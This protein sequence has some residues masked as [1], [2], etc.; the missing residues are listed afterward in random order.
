MKLK[1]KIIAGTAT[2]AF[3]A[4]AAGSLQAQEQITNVFTITA[5]I[6]EQ[7]GTNY[8]GAVTTVAA[9]TKSAFNTKQILAFLAK[10]EHAAGTYTPTNFP[11]GAKLVVIVSSS[12]A[13]SFCQVLDKN[14][15]FLVD[16]TN[17]LK[18]RTNA[19]I[20]LYSGKTKNYGGSAGVLGDPTTTTLQVPTI[21]YDDSGITNSVGIQCSLVGLMKDTVTY[22]IVNR[23]TLVVTTSGRI[24]SF[25]GTGTNRGTP[26]LITGSL[27]AAGRRTFRN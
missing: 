26:F 6:Q 1:T 18:F 19:P 5:T 22:T 24:A 27:T 3:V 15:N 17:I 11:P 7:A 23:S 8:N 12:D 9:P 14:N 25:A 10:D 13:N 16:V 2:L 20:Q 4:F 21:A